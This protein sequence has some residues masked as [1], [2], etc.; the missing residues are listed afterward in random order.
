MA[1]EER[2]GDDDERDG[3]KRERSKRE[4]GNKWQTSEMWL[5][6]KLARASISF[7]LVACR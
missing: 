6:K 7:N 4:E 2:F 5:I 1:E 3:G